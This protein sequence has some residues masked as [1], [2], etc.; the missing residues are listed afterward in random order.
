MAGNEDDVEV[1][2]DDGCIKQTDRSSYYIWQYFTV[3]NSSEAKK[4]G[5]KIAVCKFCDKSFSGCCTTRAAAHILGRPVLGQTKAGIQA[6][7]AINKKDDDRRAI[8]RNAQRA[9]S[10]VM[11][12]KEEAARTL[13][14]LVAAMKPEARAKF[15]EI[16]D[17]V[18]NKEF[19]RT[20]KCLVELSAPAM[21]LLRLVRDV[22]EGMVRDVRE[23]LAP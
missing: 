11:R 15:A 14:G 2:V 23:A 16:V 17:I 7:I 4:G 22:R 20:A 12:G 21:N 18:Q 9:L 13:K 1:E 19:W 3:S 10:E 6:C 8:L 5:A